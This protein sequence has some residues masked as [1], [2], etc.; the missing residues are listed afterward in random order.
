MTA[1]ATDRAADAGRAEGRT[2]VLSLG[3]GRAAVLFTAGRCARPAVVRALYGTFPTY[4]REFDA[5]CRALDAGLPVPLAVAVFAPE[6]GVDARLLERADF[7]RAVLL[8]HQAALYRT[9]QA[10]GVPVGAVAGDGPGSV[11]AAYA[12]G[13]LDVQEAAHRMLAESPVPAVG[14]ARGLRALRDA[15][16]E[17]LLSCGPD[18]TGPAELGRTAALFAALTELQ[19]GG[20]PV[21]WECLGHGRGLVERIGG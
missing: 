3:K 18:L 4:R 11:T 10:W 16:Y 9:W 14:A 6:Q 21:D 2:P 12:A 5:V 13:L 17:L 15:G 7:G 1:T 19:V 8:A 20:P